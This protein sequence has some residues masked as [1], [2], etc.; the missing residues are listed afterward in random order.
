[1]KTGDLETIGASIICVFAAAD[2]FISICGHFM[3]G[4]VRLRMRL[5][6]A[7]FILELLGLSL[8]IAAFV[9]MCRDN[10]K[11]GKRKGVCI[12]RK[13]QRRRRN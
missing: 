9:I 10:R 7:I 8:M 6:P 2:T 5:Y 1:M 3:D 11:K 4:A 12:W 13:K